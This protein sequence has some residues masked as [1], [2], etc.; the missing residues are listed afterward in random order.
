MSPNKHE[1]ARTTSSRF[2]RWPK[3]ARWTLLAAL[4]VIISGASFAVVRARQATSAASTTSTLQ[5]ATARTGNLV[6]QASGSGYLVASSEASIAFEID[7]KLAELDVKLGD[8]VEKGQLLARLDDASLQYKLEEAQLALLEL[9]SP[10]AIANAE[11][12]V[13]TAQSDVINAQAALNNQQYWK[14]DKL[15]ENYYASFVIAKENLDRAQ[16]AYDSANVGEYINNANEAQAYQM[17]YSAQQAYNTAHFYFSLYS[18]KPTQRQLDAAQATLDLA[19]SKLTNAQSYL[20]ALTGRTVPSDATGSNIAALKQAQLDI[21]TAQTNLDSSTLYAPMAGVVMTLHV[22]TGE[23][24]S[25]NT[26][27]MTIDDLSKA[28]IQFYL[29]AND[30]TN[31]KVGYESSV[32][33]DALMGQTFSGKV[34]E[35]MPGLVSVQGS[36]MVEGMAVLDKSVDEIGLPVGVEAAIDVISGQATNAVLV[37]VEA[38]HKLSNNSYTVFIMLNGTPT[39]RSVEV[40]LQDDTYAEIKS[41]LKAGD[42]VTTGVVETK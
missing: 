16:K 2:S 3:W 8:T 17:L 9:T 29:D 13:T 27:I 15:I 30:W 41:G 21:K 42:V 5:T 12:A 32:S 40:G 7:G 10:E 1:K 24:I 14:N 23:T 36:S 4:L 37:P 26:T 22:T 34:T 39:L 38:L 25:G 19:K 33:F 11:L 35:I 20:A 6:L 18:Q 28:T 31:A